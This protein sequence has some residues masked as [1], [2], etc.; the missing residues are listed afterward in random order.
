MGLQTPLSIIERTIIP[1]Q[2]SRHE[3]SGLCVCRSESR[4]ERGAEWGSL[5]LPGAWPAAS[6]TWWRRGR[7][8]SFALPPLLAPGS[9]KPPTGGERSAHVQSCAQNCLF[10][11]VSANQFVNVLLRF[12]LRCCSFCDADAVCG[13]VDLSMGSGYV[14]TCVQER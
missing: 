3:G 9:D 11:S 2:P 5:P 14:V 1:Q 10:P 13:G 6:G 8:G 12:E 7:P 4:S